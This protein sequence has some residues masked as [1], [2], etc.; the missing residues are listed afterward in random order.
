MAFDQVPFSSFLSWVSNCGMISYGKPYTSIGMAVLMSTTPILLCWRCTLGW[1]C[2]WKR[3]AVDFVTVLYFAS[4][5]KHIHNQA[6]TLL[7]C[8][9]FIWPCLS[10][11]YECQS[12]EGLVFFCSCS[13]PWRV[14]VAED[15]VWT[16]LHPQLREI[17]G[18][19]L[20]LSMPVR[21]SSKLSFALL[22]K[23]A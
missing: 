5:T 17:R 3:E 1:W 15:G 19:T 20:S 6:M 11:Q 22:A 12:V 14:K 18:E 13:V 4:W 2:A 8:F 21:S 16:Q 7:D 10:W 9:P 23:Y